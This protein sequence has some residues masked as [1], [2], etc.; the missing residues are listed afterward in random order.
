MDEPWPRE[1]FAG[2]DGGTNEPADPRIINF[3]VD[4]GG[5]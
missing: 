3:S 2:V 1:R 5:L 4:V